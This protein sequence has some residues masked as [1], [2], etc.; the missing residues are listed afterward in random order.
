MRNT[1]QTFILQ[2][3]RQMANGMPFVRFFKKKNDFFAK[4]LDKRQNGNYNKS[5]RSVTNKNADGSLPKSSAV[6]L[7]E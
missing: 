2:Y 4:P 3:M 1:S 5:N 6:H 7:G